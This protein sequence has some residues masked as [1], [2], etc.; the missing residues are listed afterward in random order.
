MQGAGP[1][2][3]RRS[4]AGGN[5]GSSALDREKE[6]LTRGFIDG[7][8]DPNTPQVDFS[9]DSWDREPTEQQV[10]SMKR[11]V[12]RMEEADSKA[13]VQPL[14]VP[15]YDLMWLLLTGLF[16]L[17]G[18][19]GSGKSFFM[20]EVLW[21][22][23]DR[24]DFTFGF[25]PNEDSAQTLKP[26]T[27]DG[28]KFP[29]FDPQKMKDILKHQRYTVM[30]TLLL[31]KQIGVEDVEKVPPQY[32]KFFRLVGIADDC[33]ADP[34]NINSPLMADLAF[35]HRHLKILF[36]I[37]VQYIMSI[38]P[39]IRDMI[40]YGAFFYSGSQKTQMKIMRNACPLWG[41]DA[42]ALYQFRKYF[43]ACTHGGRDPATGHRRNKY[44]CMF[45][46]Y[47][48]DAGTAKERVFVYKAR[49][50]MS[51]F[52]VGDLALYYYSKYYER[53]PKTLE[54]L[55]AEEDEKL[56][57]QRM[58]AAAAN[59][60]AAGRTPLE[61][62]TGGNG[63]KKPKRPPLPGDDDG[64]EDFLRPIE[65]A[66]P[67]APEN[68][69][70]SRHSR[71][72]RHSHGGGGGSGGGHHYSR[73][74]DEAGSRHHHHRRHGSGSHSSR[75]P[76]DRDELQTQAL[77]NMSERLRGKPYRDPSRPDPWGG[78][79]QAKRSYERYSERHESKLHRR[80]ERRRQEALQA[81]PRPSPVPQWNLKNPLQAAAVL[82][83][84][85]GTIQM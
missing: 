7:W 11:K 8:K 12:R 83:A 58:E 47:V 57:M 84:Y 35:N 70:R 20:S 3:P 75:R 72:S 21:F 40:W 30:K 17:V 41:E 19:P 16:L 81:G 34:K 13:G 39:K 5:Q 80:R 51:R 63:K 53:P 15:P 28:A 82:P 43:L 79:Y 18:A 25:N 60:I 52:R 1:P 62:A 44:C 56:E 73:H 64:E 14:Q 65:A 68:P 59:A 77:R 66:V 71:H 2:P 23:R 69:H 31:G 78:A 54:E 74:H 37:S 27:A 85:D 45:V 10:E 55:E 38:H 24:V 29:D 36:L 9:D 46:D 48:R 50:R 4:L 61:A 42:D 22:L 67:V 26:Y 32:R 6:R 33:M 76:R 49:K